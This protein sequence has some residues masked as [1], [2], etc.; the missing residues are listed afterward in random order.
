MLFGGFVIG[1]WR[2]GGIGV[3]LAIIAVVL[4]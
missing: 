4:L 1:N 2:A 3:A